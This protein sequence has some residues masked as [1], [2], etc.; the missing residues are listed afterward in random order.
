MKRVIQVLID[1]EL[2]EGDIRERNEVAFQ[3]KTILEYAT[4]PGL[5][6]RIINYHEYLK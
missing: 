1:V 5:I 3:V 6:V 2:E 4:K